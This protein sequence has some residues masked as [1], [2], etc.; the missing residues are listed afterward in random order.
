L[1]PRQVTRNLSEIKVVMSWLWACSGR[2]IS[3]IGWFTSSE[4]SE[5]GWWIRCCISIS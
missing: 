2:I 4:K 3:S 5:W 1:N